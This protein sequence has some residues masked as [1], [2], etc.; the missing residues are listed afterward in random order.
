MPSI[1]GPLRRAVLV[2]SN[3]STT[4]TEEM[5]W[6]SLFY[7]LTTGSGKKHAGYRYKCGMNSDYSANPRLNRLGLIFRTN[8]PPSQEFFFQPSQC[9]Q[10]HG[11]T[12]VFTCHQHL[13][14]N[15]SSQI[16][17][18]TNVLARK[19]IRVFFQHSQC[20]QVDGFMDVFTCHQYLHIHTSSQIHGFTDVLGRKK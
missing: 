9:S 13:H 5:A 15:T 2:L 18:F 4:G 8:I 20:S 10:V 14:I 6:H 12:D 17:G 1:V 7:W 16:H 19:E 11:F 3:S